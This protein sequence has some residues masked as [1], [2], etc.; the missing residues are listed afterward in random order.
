MQA[1]TA[2]ALSGGIDSL[3]AAA[4]LRDRGCRLIALHFLSGY[5]A[6]GGLCGTHGD[7]ANF[8][9]LEN[10]ARRSIL[11]LAD[12][13]DIPLH[14]IDLR[15]EFQEQVVDYFVD[16]YGRGQT[17]NPCLV[18]NPA[19][20]FTIL[21]EKARIWGATHIASGHYATIEA[22]D[23]GR[24]RLLAGIDKRKDQ[25]YFLAR[26]SQQQLASAVLPLGKLTKEQTRR[27]AHSKGL[28][29]ATTTESQDICFINEGTYN[30]FLA[31]QPGF[32][33]QPGSIEDM[34]G[35]VIGSHKGLHHYT[36]G[37]RRGIN[38]PAAEPYYVVQ[39]DQQ[40]NC[41]R[42][43][44]KEDL[45]TDR[46]RVD[47]I[48]WIAPAPQRPLQVMV[49]VRYR[50]KA[51]SALL[52]PIDTN[53]VEIRFDAPEPAVTPGQGAVFYQDDEVLGGGWIE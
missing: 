19:I 36:V 27:I 16:T 53:R 33:S 5:E 12:Q 22:A 20:K 49:R 46:C 52:S 17:P 39:I 40:R 15:K 38:C 43:G 13:L 29:P 9:A 14:I 47:H 21:L 3:V 35:H 42:V 1:C 18:C 41:L 30:D 23:D 37:Q 48:N 7:D 8:A 11:P 4:L 51:V 31:R 28:I 50:H 24:M 26:L 44:N 32:R 10:R 25:S 2:I 34:G 45:L 6:G